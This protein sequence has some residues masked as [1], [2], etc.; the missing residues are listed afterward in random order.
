MARLLSTDRPGPIRNREDG[1]GPSS[2]CSRARWGA[3]RQ[4]PA[5]PPAL[6]PPS[7]PP[8]CPAPLSCC[9]P[10][11]LL[12][13]SPDLHKAVS[14]S[15]GSGSHVPPPRRSLARPP[16]QNRPTL[17]VLP[18]HPTLLPWGLL[19]APAIIPCRLSC[20]RPVSPLTANPQTEPGRCRAGGR[21]A[22][23]PRR[24]AD[25]PRERTG[26]PA[27]PPSLALPW[28]PPSSHS[29]ARLPAAGRAW[30]GL[31]WGRLRGCT[32]GSTAVPR[33]VP[34]TGGRLEPAPRQ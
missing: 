25:R 29:R 23:H 5:T 1:A 12:E 14:S 8:A 9:R 13:G 16:S 10:L 27:R 30:A 15:V 6:W 33:K 17:P 24:S 3:G 34:R 31:G 18:P 22:A 19:S 11:H 2:S 7:P 21:S 26:A 4:D 32:R 28:A 20:P